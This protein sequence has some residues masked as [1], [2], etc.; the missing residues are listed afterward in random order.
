M[1]SS[2]IN[3]HRQIIQGDV[4]ERLAK[5]PDGLIDCI[6]TSPPYWAIRD[7]SVDDQWGLE[8]TFD[9]YLEKMKLLMTQLYRVLKN[10]GTCWINLGDTYSTGV[11]G[12][13]AKSRIGI[14]ERFYIHCIDSGWISRNDLTWIKNNAMPQSVKDR[15]TNKKEPVYFF[16]KSQKYYFNLDA[17]R[18]QTTNDWRSFA[19]HIRDHNNGKAQQKFGDMARVPS[20]EELKKYNTDG[21]K[22][23]AEKYTDE[24]SNVS[25]LHK[26]RK[27][28]EV[29]GSNGKPKGTYAGFNERWK[30]R[31]YQEQT[32]SKINSGG[33]NSITGESLNNPKGK[34]PGDLIFANYSDQEIFEW[35]KLC[36]DNLSA[37][38]M[39][40]PDLFCINP[41]PMPESHFA[42]FPV[43]LPQRILKCACPKAVCVR[44]GTPKSPIT[45]PTVQYERVLDSI[46]QWQRGGLEKGLSHYK[47]DLGSLTAQYE[48]VGYD[49]CDCADEFIPGI[50]LDPFFGAGTTGIAA[51][52]EGVR[53]CG[54]ELKE[55]YSTIAKKRLSTYTRQ[56]ALVI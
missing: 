39:A 6:I 31:K 5:I 11:N 1:I 13:P 3:Y 15:F 47:K 38:D 51:E 14:P 22:K 4:L 35:I 33:F 19:L 36:R 49:T 53:W 7:Y 30:D 18:I 9:E 28:D 10:T 52:K 21:T 24:N 23:I 2:Q 41:K 25:R 26:D 32:I 55:E 56:E 50:V 34:N 46:I 16:A 43:A 27:Q 45:K 54:I 48:I 17:V 20:E 40:P 12:I 8:K 29:L 37:W 42:T 44:C